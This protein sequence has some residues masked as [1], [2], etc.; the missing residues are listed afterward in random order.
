[1]ARAR[2]AIFLASATFTV[3]T[4]T[5]FA[6]VSSPTTSLQVL[7]GPLVILP[8]THINGLGLLPIPALSVSKQEYVAVASLVRRSMRQ[9][10]FALQFPDV[11]F[12]LAV[13]HVLLKERYPFI[14]RPAAFPV[15]CSP[16]QTSSL[17][18]LARGRCKPGSL[19]QSSSFLTSSSFLSSDL[20]PASSLSLSETLDFLNAVEV[21][22][23]KR[24][25]RCDDVA[26]MMLPQLVPLQSSIV[27]PCRK[28]CVEPAKPVPPLQ[29]SWVQNTQKAMV[30]RRE[31][32]SRP[33]CA[34]PR[35]SL[36]Q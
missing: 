32:L 24:A 10:R 25:Q 17:R 13:Q 36:Y 1:M 21:G 12:D 11:L 19:S 2:A 8:G 14:P 35:N 3:F 23:D 5:I 6:H 4:T 15:W 9:L 33:T 20:P 18:N 7:P 34:G 29:D 30:L 16:T 22:A 31:P 26:A 27:A 28:A